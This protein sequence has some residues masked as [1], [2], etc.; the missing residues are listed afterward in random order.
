M[1]NQRN[2]LNTFFL[3]WVGLC[4]FVGSIL[5]LLYNSDY[6]D[7]LTEIKLAEKN[8]VQQTRDTIESDL[9]GVISNLRYLASHSSLGSFLDYPTEQTLQT[10]NPAW[11]C[12]YARISCKIDLYKFLR[13]EA[14]DDET[15]VKTISCGVHGRNNPYN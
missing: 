13:A 15:L 8:I 12:N 2:I 11:C 4:I 7:E 10:L 1:L 14:A 6:K 3:V 9:S 5:Y